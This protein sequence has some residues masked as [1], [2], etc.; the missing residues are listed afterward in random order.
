ML[1]DLAGAPDRYVRQN[2][3]NGRGRAVS[4]HEELSAVYAD[5]DSYTVPALAG[6]APAAVFE[7]ALDRLRGDG[8]PEPSLALCSGRGLCL[9]WHHRPVTR[10]QLPTWN[11]C[12]EALYRVLRPL[13]ADRKA[14]DAARVLRL[15]G[16]RNSKNGGLVYPLRD[17]GDVRRFD[18]LAEALVP[19]AMPE[20]DDEA[21]DSPRADLYDLAV[22]RAARGYRYAPNGWSD[23][24]L[25][26]G[27]LT[28][29]QTLRRL[30]YGDRQME[31]FRDRWLFI[32]GVAISWLT[33]PEV[34]ER[35]VLALAQQAGGWDE[36]R[37]CLRTTRSRSAAML[38]LW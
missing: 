33:I 17:A 2:R 22:Q 9:V 14:R 6:R 7:L 28:D 38:P 10:K 32:A 1:Y 37:L 35:E 16:T 27:R 12:Q 36:P 34:L 11:V 5:I 18:E 29:L 3:F 19:L 20:A 21:R 8:I 4:Q 23:V 15:V 13:G 24:S 25:W 26:E 30:W 31:D